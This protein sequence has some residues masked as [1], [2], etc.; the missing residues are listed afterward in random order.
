[1]G[2]FFFFLLI[3]IISFA[4]LYQWKARYEKNLEK[5]PLPTKLN[6]T[7][8][9]NRD[10]LVDKAA[11]KGILIVITADFRSFSEQNKLYAKGRTEEGTIVTNAQGGESYH[12]YGLAIDFAL[13]DVNGQ[14]IWDMK[15]DGNGNGKSDW[16]EVVGIA[17]SLGFE[18][19]GDWK[20]FKDYPHLQMNFGLSIGD[21][22]KG[23]RTD[24]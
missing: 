10:I 21:L 13:L 19:G 11:D 1:M 14:V 24:P 15:Y 16:M 2:C 6:E 17:K 9:Q 3:L 8:A 20:S 4:S 7:V 18:W 22:Q 5:T 23:K 12:N